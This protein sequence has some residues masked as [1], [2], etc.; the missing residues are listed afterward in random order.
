MCA[1]AETRPVGTLAGIGPKTAA[2]LAEVDIRTEADLRRIGAVDAYRRLKHRDPKRTSLN[3][4]WG[5][6]AA[7]AGI[8]WTAIDGATKAALLAAIKSGD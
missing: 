5:I 7:L 4:F 8:P 3:A 1:G 2:W 6:H